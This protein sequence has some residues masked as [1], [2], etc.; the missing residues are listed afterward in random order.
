MQNEINELNK[1]KKEVNYYLYIV[2]FFI[3]KINNEISHYKEYINYFRDTN[4]RT[5]LFSRTINLII[6]LTYIDKGK[7]TDN[8]KNNG[9]KNKA[10]LMSTS[11]L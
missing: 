11:I 2:I 4:N 6:L 9:E 8:D 7:D 5:N 1:Q 10:K 3:N